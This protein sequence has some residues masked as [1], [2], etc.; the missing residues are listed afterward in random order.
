MQLLRQGERGY[1]LH[2]YLSLYSYRLLHGERSYRLH[3]H[4]IHP[5]T[6]CSVSTSKDSFG[7]LD[8]VTSHATGSGCD[9]KPCGKHSKMTG[10]MITESN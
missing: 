5:L 1:M 9:A 4:P 2:I 7:L 10:G 6:M 8:W 3:I